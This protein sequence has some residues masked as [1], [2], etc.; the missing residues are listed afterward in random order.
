MMPPAVPARS[1]D[2]SPGK[3][4]YP[5]APSIRPA[6]GAV[7]ALAYPDRIAKR[8]GETGRFRLSGGQG[9]YLSDTDPLAGAEFL[10]IADL[11]G[12]APDA[13]IWLAAPLSQGELELALDARIRTDDE[14]VFE[15]TTRSVQARRRRRLGALVLGDAPLAKP[16]VAAVNAA[17][18]DGIRQTGLAT[19]PWSEAATNFRQRVAFAARVEGDWPALDD[20]SLTDTP[21]RLAGP[22]ARRQAQ[23]GRSCQPRSAGSAA[24]PARLEP[25]ADIGSPG[26]DPCHRALR[27]AHSPST[28]PTRRRCWRVKLQGDVRAGRDA[29]HRRRPGPPETGICCRRPADRS[30]SRATSAASGPDRTRQCVPTCAAAIRATP[31]R[32]IRWKRCRPRAPSRGGREAARHS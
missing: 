14:V 9:A 8:R 12:Q 4:T 18:I 20:A 21:G 22:G 6:R 13:R 26:T 27:L 10:A 2:G 24:R 16:A 19:L 3:S 5:G 23:P 7:L 28:M 30:R 29:R 31:G 25:A 1:R 11:D 32:K 17:L 15:P